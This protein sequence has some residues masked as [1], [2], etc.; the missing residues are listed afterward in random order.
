MPS[1]RSIRPLTENEI[2]DLHKLYRQTDKADLRTRCQMI[3]LSAEGYSVAEIAHLTFFE[4]DS[5]LYWFER[6]EADNLTG[7]E[8]RSRF[9]RPPKSRWPM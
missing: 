8:D 3:L 7:L 4:E 6:Y 2:Q 9:G 1:A 5:V